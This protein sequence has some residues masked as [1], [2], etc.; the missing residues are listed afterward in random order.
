MALFVI[1]DRSRLDGAEDAPAGQ[2]G[3]TGRH[4][5]PALADPTTDPALG[6]RSTPS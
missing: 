1:T 6:R 5:W 2:L 4:A 3:S